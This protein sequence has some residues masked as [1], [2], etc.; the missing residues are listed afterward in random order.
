MQLFPFFSLC[1]ISDVQN[2][3]E[4]DLI[5]KEKI[6]PQYDY[7]KILLEL[8]ERKSDDDEDEESSRRGLF[9]RK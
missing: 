8:S 2:C 5:E 3:P 1:N 4:L 9:R 6:D 7:E